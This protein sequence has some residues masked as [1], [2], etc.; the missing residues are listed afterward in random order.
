VVICLLVNLNTRHPFI[1]IYGAPNL[2]KTVQTT[3]LA[4][5]IGAQYIK[6][7][8]YTESPTGPRINSIL[9]TP[10]PVEPIILQREFAQ[11]R[12][13]FEVHL[14]EILQVQPVVGEAYT[15]TGIING[16]LEGIPYETL[17]EL[18]RDL[19]KEDVGI[20]LDGETRFTG[21][22]ERGHRFEDGA[23]WERTRDLHR[24]MAEREG[25]RLV[26]AN[27]SIEAV[28]IDLLEAVTQSLSEITA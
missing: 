14:N 27:Q 19:L 1:V 18:N 13:A 20:L 22:I 28:Q 6:Y 24:E 11:N 5:A 12:R 26:N 17:F 16:M 10:L 21:G 7:P 4:E 2:G 8:V 3:K 15:C 23:D 25:W 9:R